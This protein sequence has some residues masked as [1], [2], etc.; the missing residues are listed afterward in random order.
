MKRDKVSLE[1]WIFSNRTKL[2]IFT[3]IVTALMALGMALLVV[4]AKNAAIK[5]Q[6][7]NGLFFSLWQAALCLLILSLISW[8]FFYGKDPR[9]MGARE[10]RDELFFLGSLF[11]TTPALAIPIAW[12][13]FQ[14]TK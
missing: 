13:F 4:L 9:L 10:K 14:L 2:R 7:V 8:K 1:V 11:A 6:P 5:N 12:L 3:I